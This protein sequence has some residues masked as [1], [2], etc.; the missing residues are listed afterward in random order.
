MK[1]KFYL[2]FALWLITSSSYA[3]PKTAS[4]TTPDVV[5]HWIFNKS[6][7]IQS[8]KNSEMSEKEVRE[9][10]SILRPQEIV[11]TETLYSVY[12][13]NKEPIKTAYSIVDGPDSNGCFTLQFQNPSIPLDIQKHEF[14]VSDNRLFFPA[15]KGAKA[16]LD[17]KL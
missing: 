10:S 15:V 16:V 1:R 6:E 3:E 13:P 9:F 12:R 17:R 14:C 5:G 11:I 8:L 4:P 2:I 7:T